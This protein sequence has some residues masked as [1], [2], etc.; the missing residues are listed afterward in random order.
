MESKLFVGTVLLIAG[1]EPT[2]AQ[3]QVISKVSSQDVQFTNSGHFNPVWGDRGLYGV[4]L[5]PSDEP[6][7]WRVDRDGNRED[8]RFAFSGG[9]HITING[10]AEAPDGGIVVIGGALSGDGRGATFLSCIAADHATKTITRLSPFVPW[11]LTVAP[12]GVI[13]AV[14]FVR[15][16][17]IDTV[18]AFNVLER[19][20]HNGKL[21]ST[22]ALQVKGVPWGGGGDATAWS[23]LRASK[24]RVGWLTTGN[25]YIEFSLDGREISR[26]N[27]PPGRNDHDE[28]WASFVLS[29]TNTVL[30]GIPSNNTATAE[31]RLWSLDRRQRS[32]IAVPG[33]NLSGRTYLFGADGDAILASGSL[34]TLSGGTPVQAI[35]RYVI[36]QPGAAPGK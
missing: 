14:G 16:S 35:V 30:I 5:N 10:V 21:L 17:K 7:L 9:R 12:D 8:L 27:G 32:W 4:D 15:G 22:E 33:E 2:S 34:T 31:L 13:W 29:S 19:F 24:D 11:A 23:V 18:E 20:D 6:I 1:L 3:S 25:E 36:A 28:I 26:V